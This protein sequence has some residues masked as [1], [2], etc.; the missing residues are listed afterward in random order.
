MIRVTTLAICWFV[1]ISASFAVQTNQPVDDK[2]NAAVSKA[3]SNVTGQQA[4]LLRYQFH[5][6]ARFRW[7]VEHV[8]T[9]KTSMAEFVEVV[10]SRTQSTSTW[11]VRSVDSQG[12]ATLEQTIDSVNLWRRIGDQEPTSF[13]SRSDQNPP[14]DFASA[15][16]NVGLPQPAIVVDTKG[17]VTDSKR[18]ANDYDF[19]AG[20]FW[21]PLPPDPVAIG[22]KWY[23]PGELVARQDDGTFKRIKTRMAYELAQVIDGVATIRFE[24]EVLTPIDSPKVRS[25]ICQQMTRGSIDFNLGK[26]AVQRK[27]VSWN[28]KVVGFEGGDSMT[29][30]LGEYTI[31]SVDLSGETDRSESVAAAKSIQLR[32]REQPPVFR[33]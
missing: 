23:V 21:I 12:Q 22:G 6:G 27:K 14:D 20:S 4:Y 18:K 31:N 16:K 1:F 29:H 26:G 7:K 24:H 3:I 30:Y 19:G 10:S 5:D 13:D 28:E 2:I 25:Q 32:T 33:R 15:A 11:T 9:L 17:N 8:Q